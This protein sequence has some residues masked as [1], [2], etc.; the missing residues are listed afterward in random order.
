MTD[1][2]NSDGRAAACA[3]TITQGDR[4]GIAMG[5]VQSCQADFDI[6]AAEIESAI[7]IAKADSSGAWSNNDAAISL[8]ILN[9]GK[10]AYAQAKA[11]Q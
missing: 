10:H 1:L 3:E 2:L 9:Y 6:L 11:A 4:A 7:T 5:T 8:A